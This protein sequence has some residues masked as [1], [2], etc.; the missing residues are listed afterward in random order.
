MQKYGAAC[1]AVIGLLV[2]VLPLLSTNY[3]ISLDGPTHL[4]NAAV[5]NR[6]LVND[7]FA[8]AYFEINPEPVPNYLV[9]LFLAALLSL[10]HSAISLKIFHILFILAFLAGFR[11]WNRTPSSGYLALFIALPFVYS[12]VFLNGFYNFSLGI[13]LLFFTLGCY[14]RSSQG[15]KRYLWLSLF[16]METYFAHSL[17]FVFCGVLLILYEVHSA[18]VAQSGF[19]H[20]IK[21][22]SFLAASALIPIALSLIFLGH[23]ESANYYLPLKQLLS[24][25][26]SGFALVTRSSAASCAKLLFLYALLAVL[27]L[28]VFK[29][30]K[31]C[32]GNYLL[33]S[34]LLF[35]AAYFTL[36]DSVGYAGVFSVRYSFIF[37]LL[38]AAWVARNLSID[39]WK[40]VAISLFALGF[41]FLQ[42]GAQWKHWEELDNDASLLLEAQQHLPEHSVIYPVF[43]SGAWNHFHLSNLLGIDKN[44]LILENNGARND[45]FPVRYR[46]AY[47]QLLQ[48]KP[49]FIIE[50]KKPVRIDYVIKIGKN[51]P[52][53]HQTDSVLM[54]RAKQNG[55]L[56]FENA[57]VEVWEVK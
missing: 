22:L 14:E 50:S 35:L 26:Y 48:A 12:T 19:K 44:V 54:Q 38:I 37:W 23:R 25:L 40:R 20:L 49:A 6:L 4:Y 5:Y 27:I 9:H 29:R 7:S 16:L 56:V 15:L 11:Y 52:D 41:V 32:S 57:L 28:T 17:A 24:D 30:L 18:V 13:V 39:R 10:F 1:L 36:P 34:A 31:S 51:D 8:S 43:A 46:E 42:V 21:Q 45:Y 33:W 3:L 53:F 2:C 55:N 47:E